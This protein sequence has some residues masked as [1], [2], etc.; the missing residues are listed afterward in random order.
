MSDSFEIWQLKDDDSTRL[1][2]FMGTRYLAKHDLTVDLANYE[3]TYAGK[4]MPGTTLEALFQEFN[5]HR[6]DDFYGHSMSVS[7]VVILTQNGEKTAHYCDSIGFTDVSEFVFPEEAMS[8]TSERFMPEKA[9]NGVSRAEI[10]EAV[11]A[12]GRELL[13][14]LGLTDE[15]Q[16]NAAR[17]FGSRTREGVY[18]ENSDIDVVISYTG[19]LREED[20]F[21]A[22][23][24][25]EWE[26]AGLSIDVN[27]ISTDKTGTLDAYLKAAD[28]Y[29]DEKERAM[30]R[31]SI[32]SRLKAGGQQKSQLNSQGKSQGKK[33]E[34]TI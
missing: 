6:P 4:L 13:E 19:N 28:A 8:R 1:L 34:I 20:F 5:I 12:R 10:E 16:L 17:V 24:E 31:P 33:T 26:I 22:F 7:D 15:V 14:E 29:L 30:K 2:R 27:P 11:L 9:L 25:G 21:N 32:R 23:H 18:G 3:Q